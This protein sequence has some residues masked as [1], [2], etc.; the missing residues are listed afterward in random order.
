MNSKTAAAA[1]DRLREY[2]P[3]RG[4]TWQYLNSGRWNWATCGAGCWEDIMATLDENQTA[5]LNPNA[6][7][8][9]Q[10][11]VKNVRFHLLPK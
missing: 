11:K 9:Y 4:V 6:A 2:A 8:A 7:P 5:T 3:C 10:I 1:L